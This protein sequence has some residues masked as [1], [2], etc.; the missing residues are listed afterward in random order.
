MNFKWYINR[1]KKMEPA[2]I[3]KK[4]IELV[5]ILC[6]RLKYK[7]S[8]KWP[9][10]RFAK[11]RQELVIQEIPGHLGKINPQTLRIY[12]DFIDLTRPIDWKKSDIY[13]KRWPCRHWSTINY[14]PGNPYGDIRINWELN[15]L[16]FLPH[17][18][19]YDPKM[20]VNIL[21]SWLRSNPYLKGPAYVATMEVSLRWISIYR[22]VCLME[23]HIDQQLRKDLTGLAL[24][25][26]KYILKRLS[27]HSSAGNH[28]IVEA[29]GL[30]W[31]GKALGDDSLGDHWQRIARKILWR[32]I[33][34]QINKDGTSKE[35]SFWYLGFVLD[36]AFHYFLME[37]KNRIPDVFLGRVERALEFVNLVLLP[38]GAFP[39]FGDRDDGYV[40]RADW[41]Y[42]ET[43]FT[44]L[45][46]VGSFYFHRSEWRRRNYRNET[47][48]IAFWRPVNS[49]HLKAECKPINPTGLID[50][51]PFLKSYPQGGM[52]VM[53]WGKAQM[54]FRHSP[55]GH[56]KTCGHGHADAL[57]LMLD[58]QETPVLIDLGSG[59]YNGDQEIRNFFRSTIAHNTIELGGRNQAEIIGPFL[60]NNLYKS[61]LIDAH[62]KPMM[63]ATA[64]HDGYAK[65]LK[66]VHTR[67]IRWGS[68]FEWD[69]IDSFAGPGGISMRGAFHL[70]ACEKVK[71]K[72]NKLIVEFSD[73][74]FSILFPQDFHLEVFRGAL[75]PFMGW[76]GGIYGKWNP[77]YSI[78]FSS[79]LKENFSYQLKLKID[80][81]EDKPSL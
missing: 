46:E 77:M 31:L 9:Y 71:I 3:A 81:R 51:D 78:V 58:F 68:P 33:P 44:G 17:I 10:S 70:G 27:T 43:F 35:Q 74:Y 26:G 15:R 75:L 20:A 11:G 42:Q 41:N 18:A 16:Q 7:D 80:S 47:G 64:N 54:I 56:G 59:Q 39:D 22:A 55:L 53:K 32:E 36:A 73:F 13:K 37:E 57:S 69:I 21:K 23:Q 38:N 49:A 24:A 30:F 12:S 1:L 79:I 4:I 65:V 60:W 67:E 66:T 25:S 72:Q 52:T 45:L 2:E 76:K 19:M 61:K 14:R 28:L 48:R 40:F 8:S 62:T 29:V 6:S 34:D 50:S 5:S 63:M